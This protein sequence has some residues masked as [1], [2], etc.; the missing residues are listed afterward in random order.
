MEGEASVGG[1]GCSRQD[2]TCWAFVFVILNV[3][4][5]SFFSFLSF[6]PLSSSDAIPDGLLTHICS[7]YVR[8]R[9][10]VG[11]FLPSLHFENEPRLLLA[12]GERSTLTSARR[13]NA[14]SVKY[15]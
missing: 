10:G 15:D 12:D 7:S 9:R 1:C 8:C 4:P 6:R 5:S 11:G 13:G 3:R 2:A 14:L